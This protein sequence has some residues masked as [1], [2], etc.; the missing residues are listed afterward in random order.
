MADPERFRGL[1]NEGG[2]ADVEVGW[3]SRTTAVLQEMQGDAVLTVLS[4]PAC[5]ESTR[6]AG[7][8]RAKLTTCSMVRLDWRASTPS[9]ARMFNQ[10]DPL[11]HSRQP[12]LGPAPATAATAPAAKA[13]GQVEA[14]SQGQKG[15]RQVGPQ[16]QQTESQG[17][18]QRCVQSAI[19]AAILD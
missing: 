9:V 17:R 18:Y 19:S 13:E 7:M 11:R 2:A 4:S 14:E 3:V 6:S 12:T 1:V 5:S 8:A 16:S 10:R 15:A